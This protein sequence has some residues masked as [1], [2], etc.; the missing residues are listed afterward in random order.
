MMSPM[1]DKG[2]TEATLIHLRSES[3]EIAA[4]ALD[5]RIAA[6]E[7][8]YKRTFLERGVILFEVEQRL[9]W[10]K[11]DDPATGVPFTSLDRWILTRCPQSRSD[12][13][14]ALRAVKELRDIPRE[15]LEAIPRCNVAILQ[16]LSTA[17]RNEPEI[18][19]AAKD[20][21]EREFILKIQQDWPGQHIEERRLIHM[22]PTK[23][24]SVVIEQAIKLAMQVEGVTTREQALEVISVEYIHGH[25][26]AEAV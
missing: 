5:C 10:Q 25:Q 3:D 4:V 1:L 2:I 19:K 9:L 23:S 8:L 18:L 26:E 24:A 13:Y 14:A 12:A 20:L 7:T 6:L 21:P 17:V 11:I 22:K 16:A 15:R